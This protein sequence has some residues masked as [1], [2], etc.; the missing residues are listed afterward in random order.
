MQG[1]IDWVIGTKSGKYEAAEGHFYTDY[2]QAWAQNSQD[3]GSHDSNVTPEK[4]IYALN[5]DTGARAEDYY[6]GG[7]MGYP[8]YDLYRSEAPWTHG[9]ILYKVQGNSYV[10][11]ALALPKASASLEKAEEFLFE[12]SVDNGATWVKLDTVGDITLDYDANDPTVTGDKN[13]S[14]SIYKAVVKLPGSSEDTV[15]LRITIPGGKD[16]G[17]GYVWPGL[18]YGNADHRIGTVVVSAHDLSQYKTIDQVPEFKTPVLAPG[19]YD[20]L[21]DDFYYDFHIRST[22]KDGPDYNW[23]TAEGYAQTFVPQTSDG[24]EGWTALIG[25]FMGQVI[26]KAYK[27]EAAWNGSAMLYEVEAGSYV[28]TA[29]PTDPDAPKKDGEVDFSC[30]GFDVSA[31]KDTWTAVTPTIVLD[32]ARAPEGNVSYFD[33]YKAVVQ[34]PEGM[35]YYRIT[36]PGFDPQAQTS[37]DLVWSP[38]RDTAYDG[39]FYIG[40]SFASAYDLTDYTD[41]TKVP[42]SPLFVDIKGELRNAI[43]LADALNLK[44]YEEDDAMEAFLAK[45]EEAKAYLNDDPEHTHDEYKAKAA[46]LDEAR[47]ALTQ[48]DVPGA[49]NVGQ[50]DTR[51]ILK[52]GVATGSR[53]PPLPTAW[54]R[55]SLEPTAYTP[56]MPVIPTMPNPPCSPRRTGSTSRR[57]A[58]CTPPLTIIICTRPSSPLNSWA[59]PS[60]ACS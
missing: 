40:P 26:P 12:S 8:V 54:A 13:P 35:K 28:A 18:D 25:R 46:E 36:L 31:D 50:N 47:A 41:L 15:Q 20:D 32:S 42:D 57:T 60:R 7:F 49:A 2:A 9:G 17:Q 4:Y 38:D 43:I 29:I 14:V 58:A 55:P 44:L 10:A 53:V 59:D 23:N 34:I 37:N 51:R 22:W 30:F 5:L 56:G 45:L 1:D 48:K 52:P 11:M 27:T 24:W 21:E 16:D 6:F 39:K 3:G 33:V 19:I